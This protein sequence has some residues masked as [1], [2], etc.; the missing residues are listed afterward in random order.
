MIVF[1]QTAK[2]STLVLLS[3]SYAPM[4]GNMYVIAELQI[5]SIQTLL[6]K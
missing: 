2:S 4:K 1:E 5:K 3:I 6:Q